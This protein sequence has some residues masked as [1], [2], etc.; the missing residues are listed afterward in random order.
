MSRRAE[1]DARIASLIS[2]PLPPTHEEVI[3]H[4]R[5]ERRRRERERFER[6]SRA[7]EHIVH[8]SRGVWL[9]CRCG[10]STADYWGHDA[11]QEAL[12]DIANHVDQKHPPVDGGGA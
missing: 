10:Y 3:E 12:A 4:E 8:E 5:A 7:H 2:A 9:Q 11:D 6:E 1:R